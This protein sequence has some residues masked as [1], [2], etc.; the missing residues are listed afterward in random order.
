MEN[1]TFV[2]YLTDLTS[3]FDKENENVKTYINYNED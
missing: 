3:C 1:F 2:N